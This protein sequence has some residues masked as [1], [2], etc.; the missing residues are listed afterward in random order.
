MQVFANLLNNA[1]RYT[2]DGGSI[3]VIAHAEDADV[4][5]DVRDTGVG[6]APDMLARVFELF[7]QGDRRSRRAQ[8]GLGIGLHLSRS[9]VQLHGGS[10]TVSS[11]GAHR[12]STFRVRLPRDASDTA[13]HA[14]A[15]VPLRAASPPPAAPPSAH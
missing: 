11:A 14:E 5:V 1:A 12:G 4:V 13:P 2:P 3:E 15:Q 9:L 8:D 6:I 10:L 7:T